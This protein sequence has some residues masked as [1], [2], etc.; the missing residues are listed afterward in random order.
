M[1]LL[2]NAQRHALHRTIIITLGDHQQTQVILHLILVCNITFIM[3]TLE[4]TVKLFEE[5]KQQFNKQTP[6]L[7][8]SKALV[9]QLKVC[10]Q[11]NTIPFC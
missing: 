1:I 6:D 3:A 5:F 9:D 2:V 4:R 10:A 7:A 8:Q 11:H